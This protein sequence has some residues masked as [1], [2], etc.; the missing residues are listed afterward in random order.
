M[1]TL[2]QVRGII[3]IIVFVGCAIWFF[4]SAMQQMKRLTKS[5]PLKEKLKFVG[6]LVWALL[7][8]YCAVEAIYP[9]VC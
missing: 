9:W 7:N 4:V 2:Q 1:E 8:V 5:S 3:H 6:V